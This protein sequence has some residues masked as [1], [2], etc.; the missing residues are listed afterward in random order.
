MARP[1]D[2]FVVNGWYLQGLP[3]LVEPHFETLE[4][5]AKGNG[6]VTIVDA[7]TNKTTTF[8]DQIITFDEFSLTRTHQGTADD[9]ALDLLVESCIQFSTIYPLVRAIKKHKLKNVLEIAFINFRFKKKSEPNWDVNGT[10][11]FTK[12]FACTCQ[13]WYEIKY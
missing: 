5:V 12:T 2:L 11:K 4:S 10:D 6:D 1:I 8:S 3:G 13:D 7:G 9:Q